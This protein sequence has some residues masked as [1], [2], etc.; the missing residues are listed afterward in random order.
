MVRGC[1]TKNFARTSVQYGLFDL[2]EGAVDNIENSGRV[3]FVE[4]LHLING[5]LLY[6]VIW[7]EIK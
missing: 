7:K 1:V 6:G 3:V 2:S 5:A 4:F